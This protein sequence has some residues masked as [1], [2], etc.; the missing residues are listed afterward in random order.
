LNFAFLIFFVHPILLKLGPLT[1]YSYGLFLSL[2]F[3]IG[4]W[5]FYIQARQK[6][7]DSEKIPDLLVWIVTA[8][9]IG[10][11]ILHILINFS[12]Y[13]ENLSAIVKFWEGGASL[14]GGLLFGVT[15]GLF[16]LRKDKKNLLLWLDAAIFGLLSGISIGKIGCFLNGCCFGKP[17]TSFL[18][19][20]FP[21]LS[22]AYIL[23]GFSKVHPTQVY[24]AIGYAIGLTIL[25][26]IEKKIK[27]IKP[28]I[29]FLIGISLQSLVRFIVEYFRYHFELPV[30]Q[31]SNFYLN[32]TFTQI[33]CL[34]III[35]SL[36]I[37]FF[38]TKNNGQRLSQ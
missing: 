10:S 32:I 24:E 11:R 1:F 38:K 21:P 25:L 29:L 4:A 35:T 23:S 37:Y 2:G 36:L 28:G 26:A 22:E 14:Y 18:G 5:I 13:K 27:N 30:I 15:T 6:K 34:G 20:K 3:I 8:S 17:T 16:F 9:L 7:L 19:V 12:Y 31:S 33:I